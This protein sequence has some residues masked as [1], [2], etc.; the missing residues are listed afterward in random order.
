VG[1][2]WL[3]GSQLTSGVGEIQPEERSQC[4]WLAVQT[5]LVEEGDLSPTPEEVKW[6]IKSSPADARK[7]A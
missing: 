6:L 1:T 4:G 3:S 5:S 2:K 7:Q